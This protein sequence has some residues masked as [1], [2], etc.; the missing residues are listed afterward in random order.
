M[1]FSRFKNRNITKI[2]P[3]FA[4]NRISA[5]YRTPSI[6]K[7]KIGFSHFWRQKILLIF[8]GSSAPIK[9]SCI[10]CIFHFLQPFVASVV[11]WVSKNIN[12]AKNPLKPFILKNRV[13]LDCN[14]DSFYLRHYFFSKVF[15]RWYSPLQQKLHFKCVSDYRHYAP[16]LLS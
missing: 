6:Y 13:K 12:G 14:F 15:G 1:P 16:P 4:K 7:G 9:Y 2:L 11:A 5:A 8:L 10:E 3:I